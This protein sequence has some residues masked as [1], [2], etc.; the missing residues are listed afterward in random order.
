M[1]MWTTKEVQ[2]VK[3][4]ALL[5]ETNEVL[6]IPEMAKKLGRTK[7]SVKSKIYGLQRDGDLPKVQRENAFDSH[8]RPWS[9]AED[10][11]L[12]A[13]YKKGV[14]HE[15]IGN[16]L[17]RTPSGVANRVKRLNDSKKLSR[18]R[19]SWKAKEKAI[20]IENVTFD[21]NGFVNNYD[22]L[23]KICNKTYQ[24]VAGKIG[25]LRKDG[26]ITVQSDR[27]KTSVKSKQAMNRFNDARF[28]QYKKKEKK[29]AME[30]KAQTDVQIETQSQMIQVIMT[31]VIAGSEKTINFFSTDG[32]LLA[33][34][35]E[36]VSF[37]DDTSQ[38]INNKLATL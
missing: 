37:A 13:L 18:N 25:R 7:E 35:K 3:R 33:I 19:R 20:L 31:T 29:P 26:V 11:K 38:E 23:Q 21:E 24:Q 22:Y 15:E 9:V 12:I 5:A 27:T 6:N 28:A 2:Y 10:K 34:K 17:N 16:N 4:V 1:K 36:P 30:N 14:T 32:Q 8:K